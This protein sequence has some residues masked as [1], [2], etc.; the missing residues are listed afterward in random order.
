MCGLSHAKALW[1]RK[2]RHLGCGGCKLLMW[3]ILKELNI[4]HG[5]GL[6]SSTCTST[7][8]FRLLS[9]QNWSVLLIMET[10]LSL[11]FLRI[12]RKSIKQLASSQEKREISLFWQTISSLNTYHKSVTVSLTQIQI[13]QTRTDSFICCPSCSFIV[14]I[15]SPKWWC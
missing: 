3:F 10:F 14:S 6:S 11:L 15:K 7:N 12:P 13:P 9:L 8:A 1:M 4:Q 5:V 2:P